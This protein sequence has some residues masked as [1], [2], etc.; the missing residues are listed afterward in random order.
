MMGGARFRAKDE[1]HA[2]HICHRMNLCRKAI[3]ENDEATRLYRFIIRV[4]G[5][6]V[7]IVPRAVLDLADMRTL[8]GK[9]L[10]RKLTD[11]ETERAKAALARGATAE[12]VEEAIKGKPLDLDLE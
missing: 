11:E 4:V 12:Q 5:D 10:P 6:E 2:I 9:P 7:H 1:R 8:D 3:A